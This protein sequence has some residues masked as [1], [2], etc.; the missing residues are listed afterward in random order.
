M[1]NTKPPVTIALS[2]LWK[3]CDKECLLASAKACWQAGD[4]CLNPSFGVKARVS[5]SKGF[6][7]FMVFTDS[8]DNEH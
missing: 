4:C 8:K 7:R 6:H 3:E 2:Q 5:R 1:E